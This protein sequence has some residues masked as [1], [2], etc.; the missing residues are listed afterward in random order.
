MLFNKQMLAIIDKYFRLLFYIF[1]ICIPA[2][3]GT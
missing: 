2:L 3:L 1:V